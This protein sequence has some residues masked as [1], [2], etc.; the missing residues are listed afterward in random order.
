MARCILL[1]TLGLFRSDELADTDRHDR[2]SSQ[3]RKKKVTHP[4]RQKIWNLVSHSNHKQ[5]KTL[6]RR[7]P[8]FSAGMQTTKGIKV[9]SIKIFVMSLSRV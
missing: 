5:Q 9:S 2:Y 6:F 4:T 3:L 7:E 1:A 8:F